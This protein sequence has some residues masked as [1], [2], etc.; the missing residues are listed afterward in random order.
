MEPLAPRKRPIQKRSMTT[1]AAILEGAAQV[2]ERRGIDAFTTNAIA[3][4]AGVSI[5][6]LYQY[7]A[8]KNSVAA[9]LSRDVRS[10]LAKR[11]SDTVDSAL[12]MPLSEG[13]ES[14]TTA[15]LEGDAV[16]PRL[17][18]ALDTLEAHLPLE[19]EG[20]SCSSS[21]SS[22]LGLEIMRVFSSNSVR[23]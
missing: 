18:K 9:A 2:L 1:V 3:E 13:L 6:T 4:Q 8:D 19:E 10:A 12:G 11:L 20:D 15:T 5:G 23:L 14:I 22:A 17:A 16:R 7:Y 21:Q